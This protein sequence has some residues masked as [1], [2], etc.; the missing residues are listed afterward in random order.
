MSIK[1]GKIEKNN[2]EEDDEEELNLE[3]Q[4]DEVNF[5]KNSLKIV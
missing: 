4:G 1:P 5:N 2:E 3:K